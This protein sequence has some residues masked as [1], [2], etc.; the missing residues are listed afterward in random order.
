MLT[1]WLNWCTCV[2]ASAHHAVTSSASGP[3]AKPFVRPLGAGMGVTRRTIQ[4][5]LELDQAPAGIVAAAK[6]L[7]ESTVVED[8]ELVFFSTY[9]AMEPDAA[10]TVKCTRNGAFLPEESWSSPASV[11]G[12]T[13][14][15]PVL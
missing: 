11:C 14:S 10:Q 8:E 1:G 4:S 12:P 5:A 2:P 6:P 9:G 13:P 3:G 15:G 7:A